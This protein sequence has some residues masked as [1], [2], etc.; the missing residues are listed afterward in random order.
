MAAGSSSA[1]L[2]LCKVLASGDSGSRVAAITTLRQA[3]GD[4]RVFKL[5]KANDVVPPLAHAFMDIL[6]SDNIPAYWRQ[7]H[8]ETYRRISTFLEELDRIAARLGEKE[9]TVL[10]IENGALARVIYP[11]PGCFTFG[12]LDLLVQRKQIPTVHRVL[13][14]AG[15]RARASKS[16]PQDLPDLSNGRAEYGRMLGGSY[17]MRLNIQWSLVARRWFE[18]TREP[19]V[20]DL[21]ERSTPIEGSAARMLCPEDNLFQLAIHNASH[22]YVRKPGIRLHLDIDRFVN[23]ARINWDEFMDLVMRYQVRTTAYFS[24][25]IPKTLFHTPIPD[26]VLA[27]LKPPGWKERLISWW[28]QKVGLFNPDEKKF[29]RVGYVI[30]KAL[31]YDD[32]KGLWRGIFP[33]KHWMRERYRIKDDKRLPLFYVKRL[34]DLTFRRTGT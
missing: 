3:L 16:L 17:T 7:S 20:E 13:T 1:D 30:F 9:V 23:Y 14:S 8:E 19:A 12:D 24:L 6:G 34:M 4:E 27:R 11:C 25:A 2:L 22:A 32:L 33:N 18:A 26:T 15:Y 5:A 31:L 10:L 28:L 21:L 29:S